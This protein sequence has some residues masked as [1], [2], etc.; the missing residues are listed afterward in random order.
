MMDHDSKNHAAFLPIF[1][2]F[3]EIIPSLESFVKKIVRET[4][5][6][7]F[8]HNHK[9]AQ[10]MDLIDISSDSKIPLFVTPASAKRALDRPQRSCSLKKKKIS[11]ADVSTS[12]SLVYLYDSYNAAN[13]ASALF[14]YFPDRRI[15]LSIK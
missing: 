13:M 12:T 6:Q 7:E 10:P 11:Y 4:I 3:K 1:R 8:S 14:Y 15:K 2:V 9:P 5:S